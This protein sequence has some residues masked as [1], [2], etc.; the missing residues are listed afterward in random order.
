LGGKVG[1][2][3]RGAKADVAVFCDPP[4]AQSVDLGRPS[5]LLVPYGGRFHEAV[6]LDVALRFAR[7]SGAE[8]T[9]LAP[10][11]RDEDAQRQAPEIPEDSGVRLE[12]VRVDGDMTEAILQRVAEF[13]LLILGVSDRWMTQQD[14]LA[15][16]GEEVME[17]ARKPYI[18]VRR[19]GGARG[20]I[21]RLRGQIKMAP[22]QIA[23]AFKS[24][25]TQDVTAVR[26]KEETKERLDRD[27]E[28]DGAA[29]KVHAET[30]RG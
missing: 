13:D 12:W 14:V 11:D 17:H 10:A 30:R 21:H 18:V 20:R 4:S 7:A 19:H 16:V 1:D 3:L 28:A 24:D 8:V 23:E 29:E 6:G 5:R 15:T 22:K 2:G 25:D 9:V 27:G 26:A